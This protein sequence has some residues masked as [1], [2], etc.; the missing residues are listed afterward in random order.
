VDTEKLKAALAARSDGCFLCKY[1]LEDLQRNGKLTDY[2]KNAN[3]EKP[4][5]P[6]AAKVWHLKLEEIPLDS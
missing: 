3:L 5:F 6:E 2:P 1:I 4:L